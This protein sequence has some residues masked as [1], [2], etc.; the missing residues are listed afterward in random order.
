LSKTTVTP[1]Y[2]T[3]TNAEERKL[4]ASVTYQAVDEKSKTE[5]LGNWAEANTF[6]ASGFNL[7]SMK[8]ISKI[9]DSSYEKVEKITK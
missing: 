1:P 6:A 7:E 5:V 2:L 3:D 9:Y 4:L 8:K